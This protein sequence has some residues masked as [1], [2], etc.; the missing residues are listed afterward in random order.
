MN[1]INLQ[2][3][4]NEYIENL[5][6]SVQTHKSIDVNIFQMSQFL[7]KRYLFRFVYFFFFFF[8]VNSFKYNRGYTYICEYE[9]K[10]NLFNELTRA[11]I[12][13][14]L[15]LMFINKP[16]IFIRGSSSK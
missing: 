11:L 7:F 6:G 16:T 13:E 15:C 8:N 5:F 2:I 9:F 3:D 10:Y 4:R 12:P 1:I 14:N